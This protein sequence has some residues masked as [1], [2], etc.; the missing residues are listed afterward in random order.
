[1]TRFTIKQP[2]TLSSV[3]YF[4]SGTHEAELTKEQIKEIKAHG[5]IIEMKGG[6]NA[7]K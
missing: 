2:L 3:G 7:H 6:N 1:M 4:P 5:A